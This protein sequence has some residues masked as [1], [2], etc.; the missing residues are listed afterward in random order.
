[1]I[2]EEGIY[3]IAYSVGFGSPV[4]FTRC[5]KETYGFRQGSDGNHADGDV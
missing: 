2:E 1:M 4:Y 3:Q 5:F